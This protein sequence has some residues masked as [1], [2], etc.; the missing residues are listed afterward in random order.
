M[1]FTDEQMA[2][3]AKYEAHFETATKANWSRYPGRAALEEILDTL[4]AATGDRRRLNAA[5]GVCYLNLL[6]DTGRLYFADKEAR[7]AGANE[8]KAAELT[9]AAAKSVELSEKKAKPRK[10]VTVK[11]EK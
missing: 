5:C 3:L 7:I 2:V 9:Q 8:K 4:K 6:K 11:T 10:K 1:T